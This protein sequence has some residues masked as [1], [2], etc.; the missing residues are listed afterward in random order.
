MSNFVTGKNIRV[1]GASNI[2]NAQMIGGE[3]I[4]VT[5]ADSNKTNIRNGAVVI[6]TTQM[7]IASGVSLVNSNFSIETGVAVSVQ[8]GKRYFFSGAAPST[9]TLDTI[10]N[11][12]GIETWIYNRGTATITVNSNAGAN[13]I[14]TG[15][16]AVNTFNIAA[17]AWAI[18]YSDGVLIEVIV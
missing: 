1:R 15:G 11:N 5:E 4:D 18:L 13:D 8:A 9:W 17:G 14:Y 12:T 7:T 2:V 6:T 3:D 10:A 16:A